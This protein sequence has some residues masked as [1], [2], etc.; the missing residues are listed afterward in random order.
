MVGIE[1]TNCPQCDVAPGQEH[2]WCDIARCK[3]TG[4]QLMQCEGERHE[5]DGREYG[6]HEGRCGPS[7]WTG[8]WP[9]VEEC[10]TLGWFTEPDSPHGVRED[11]NRLAVAEFQGIVVWDKSLQKF[12][13]P[14]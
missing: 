11:L 13:I 12:V 1:V 4:F 14:E 6:E 9:G 7:V 3:S 10:R 2:G 5:Y 8:L